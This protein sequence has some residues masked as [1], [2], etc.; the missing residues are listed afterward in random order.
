MIRIF[1][2]ILFLIIFFLIVFVF[3]I[4]YTTWGIK[5]I[6]GYVNQL[7]TISVTVKKLDGALM[8]DIKAEEI[9]IN[10]NEQEIKAFSPTIELNLR[11]L[12]LGQLSV[13][14]LS[15]SKILITI[16]ESTQAD[17]SKLTEPVTP[18]ASPIPVQINNTSIDA[19]IVHINKKDV[20]SIYKIKST[21]IE[22]RD[23]ILFKKL[24]LNYLD[25]ALTASGK[26]GLTGESNLSI[27]MD[28]HRKETPEIPE[29]SLSSSF[30]G[31]WNRFDASG[32]VLKPIVGDYSGDIKI[33]LDNF[34]WRVRVNS[35]EINLI[36]FQQDLDYQLNNFWLE[37]KG[38]L[39]NFSVTSRTK[40]SNQEIGDWTLNSILKRNKQQWEINEL[41]LTSINT[42]A[43]VR[44][45][46]YLKSEL[47]P[48]PEDEF[49]LNVSWENINWPTI[50][51]KFKS[52]K[53]QTAFT[54]T[55]EKFD[56]N[57]NTNFSMRAYTIDNIRT[58]GSG[59]MNQLTFKSIQADAFDGIWNGAGKFNWRQGYQWNF[60]VNMQNA[61]LS[62]LNPKLRGKIN[63]TIAHNGKYIDDNLFLTVSVNE[64]TARIDKHK[65]TGEA[66]LTLNDDSLMINNLNLRS[67]NSVVKGE[68]SIAEMNKKPFINAQWRVNMENLGN[69]HPDLAGSLKSVGNLH[70]G[71]ENLSIMANVDALN[72]AY[73]E[74]HIGTIKANF[75]LDFTNQRKSSLSISANELKIN[76]HNIDQVQVK[77]TGLIK[78][79]ELS[80]LIK[81]NEQRLIKLK[82][83][84]S[85][86]VKKWTGQLENGLISRKNQQQWIQN[87]SAYATIAG[88]TLAV[89][90]FCFKLQNVTT[91][92]CSQLFV[93]NFQNWHAN[94][95]LTDYNLKNIL[96]W[97]PPRFTGIDGLANAKLKAKYSP[98]SKMELSSEV[99]STHGWLKYKSS[100]KRDQR[101]EYKELN[102]SLEN[103]QK[104]PTANLVIDLVN[105]GHL[106]TTLSLPSWDL[107]SIPKKDQKVRGKID[108]HLSNLHHIPGLFPDVQKPQGEWHSIFTI[109][110]TFDDP[111]IEGRS[112]LVANK[113][114]IP[115][116]GIELS[117]LTLSAKSNAD[118]TIRFNGSTQSGDG[119]LTIDGEIRD[120][121]LAQMLGKMRISG[122]KF[123]AV[124]LPEAV[125]HISPDMLLL[126]DKEIIDLEG[127][128]VIPKADIQIFDVSGPLT[129]SPDVVFLGEEK[130]QTT[131]FN[132]PMFRFRSDIDVVLGKD[133]WMHG[134]GFEGRLQGTLNVVETVQLT[135]ATGELQI[136][137]G[138][139]SAYGKE[140][141]IT[142]GKLIFSGGSIDNPSIQIKAIR[143]I[144]QD[145][146]AGIKIDGQAR[147]PKI[148]LFSDPPMNETDILSYI[149]LG[150]PVSDASKQDGTDLSK[151][152]L[153]IGL[154]GGE[155]IAKDLAD[156]FGIDEVRIKSGQTTE[157]TSLVL[158]KYLSP[159]LYVNYAIGISQ[160]VNTLQMQYKLADQ[161]LLKAESGEY[162]GADLI[163]TFE[164]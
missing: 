110:G 73:Q 154:F 124:K 38:D 16:N 64:L 128:L 147:N 22:Y 72:T 141:I 75:D 117:R 157:Q 37:S 146:M 13:N 90:D 87:G 79:H 148:T 142:S 164:H 46:G 1:S 161:W 120:Y 114:V 43:K 17:A 98:E 21:D 94:A 27:N 7:E 18:P 123:T 91:E 126:L 8:R 54:G 159:K 152:A 119:M 135:K 106:N 82:S 4:F 19:L 129:V 139:Y 47:I 109:D 104:S 11:S 95:N 118:R 34:A 132:F 131:S 65:I 127:K 105:T 112:E 100:S 6:L 122:N 83:N 149:V 42:P 44:A 29:I 33:L 133:V 41:I 52:T 99:N 151:A 70:G 56:F 138:K 140:L 48:N 160:T 45:H 103:I 15:A 35:K 101:I 68:L 51:S 145:L 77:G 32:K 107:M 86:R 84:G 78:Q 108:F 158:G 60:D 81:M 10:I 50:E 156:R 113:L 62:S 74:N 5:W 39:N 97:L 9:L 23:A 30:T 57:I 134:Y 24:N 115:S 93:N 88:D 63:S 163:F 49:N 76:S 125:V 69:F 137:D 96:P 40:I 67:N 25:T 92:F 20:Y 102:F 136:L 12:L 3:N 14:S 85:Y 53:G 143:E 153:S 89:K 61:D 59:N 71:V 2:Y 116:V 58:Y 162:H 121:R 155:K 130:Q 111:L 55:L 28:L 144:N 36:K 31:T 150:Y 66:H 80:L 26:F